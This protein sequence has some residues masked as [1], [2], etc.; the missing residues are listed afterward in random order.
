[1]VE[2]ECVES[3]TVGC[4]RRRARRHYMGDVGRG[5]GARLRAL[6]SRGVLTVGNGVAQVMNQ[7]GTGDYPYRRL[8]AVVPALPIFEILRVAGWS[9]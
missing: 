8:R 9:E 6:V 5:E 3:H 1:M 2:T 4:V 7:N